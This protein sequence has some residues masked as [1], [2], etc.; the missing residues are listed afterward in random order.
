MNPQPTTSRAAEE[1]AAKYI[2][3]LPACFQ[4]KA[5]GA[6]MHEES[7]K[8]VLLRFARD[9]LV[10]QPSAQ[11]AAEAAAR[12]CSEDIQR[13][14]HVRILGTNK[15]P[16]SPQR[17][18]DYALYPEM[19]GERLAAIILRHMGH[20]APVQG[21]GT[22]CLRAVVL[23]AIVRHDLKL[24]GEPMSDRPPY[25]MEEELADEVVAAIAPPPQNEGGPLR[26]RVIEAVERGIEAC[27]IYND[28]SASAFSPAFIDRLCT[29]LAVQPQGADDAES[30]TIAQRDAAE[31]AA[32]KLTS[33]ILGEPI[34]W[35]DHA[36]K[37]EEAIEEATPALPDRDR[38]RLD[39]LNENMGKVV[40]G[41][42]DAK[43]W[44]LGMKEYAPNKATNIR[45]AID[46]ASDPACRPSLSLNRK[47]HDDTERMDW[48]DK[49]I[50][51]D[52]LLEMFGYIP[53][54]GNL[55]F[56]VNKAIDAALLTPRPNQEKP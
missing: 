2:L 51:D 39:W 48:M 41:T 15:T 35:S 7:A 40:P 29:A 11:P 3:A 13:E 27:E 8:A 47:Y 28:K 25:I 52:A 38:E 43:F 4:A 24:A 5:D 54:A 19:P 46:S 55:R 23:E 18:R 37:W 36:A 9:L 22:K 33:I 6:Y 17:P 50:S 14:F 20:L 30:L 16:L 44:M 45:A 32:D 12:A 56:A 53:S 34:D 10:A 1:L 49:K 42:D 21:G 31:E 26:E